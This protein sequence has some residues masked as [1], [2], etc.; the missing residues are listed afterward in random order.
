MLLN[1]VCLLVYAIASWKFFEDRITF[2]EMML[3]NFFG[4]AY[5]DYQR[6]VGT[7]LPFIRGYR[8]D[9]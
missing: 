5:V 6:R 3:L 8:V 9:L 7:G 1:P 2:E 4:K